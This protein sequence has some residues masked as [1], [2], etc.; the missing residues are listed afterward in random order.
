MPILDLQLKAE[1]ENLTNLK[2]NDDIDWIIKVKCTQCGALSDKVSTLT[3]SETV[4]IPNSRGT[5]HLVQKCK[6]CERQGNI[7]ILDVPSKGHSLTAEDAE[8]GKFVTIVSF[9]CR[10]AIEPVELYPRDGFTAQGVE[11]G[12]VFEVDLS[13]DFS[14]YDEKAQASVG[15]YGVQ[16]KF[17]VHR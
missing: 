7:S 2:P 1:L 16:H 3:R 12:K 14:E 8:A 4:D 10:G 17:V 6:L 9:E 11:S 5:A 13:D 15:V